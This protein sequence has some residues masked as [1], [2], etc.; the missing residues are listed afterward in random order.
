M[1][2]LSKLNKCAIHSFAITATHRYNEIQEFSLA[3]P[4]W[5]MSPHYP[6]LYKCG[7]RILFYL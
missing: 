5:Y 1:I 6:M 2:D 4:S 7:T 3:Q